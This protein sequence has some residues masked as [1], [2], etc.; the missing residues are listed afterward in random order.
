MHL[1]LV[2]VVHAIGYPGIFAIIFLESGVFFGFFLP[3]ASLLFTSGILASK[4]FFHPMV[5]IPLVTVAAILGDNTGYW[6]GK[7]VGIRL[8][9]KPD[10]TWF[11][12]EHLERAK[13]FYEKYG[14]R[15]V[16]FARFIP[17]VRTFVPIVAGIVGMNYRSFVLY[18]IVGGVTWAGGV[19]FLGYYL[20][21]RFP[22]VQQYFGFV[23]LGIIIVTTVPVMWD[24]WKRLSAE[25]AA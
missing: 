12:H 13:E 5:L 10:S 16:V 17:I 21:E 25:P 20:G 9:L 7:T 3:G 23:V 14:N 11:K 22:I 24:T 15:T 18:N 8:F 1:D 4:G 19:T 2:S 6:F